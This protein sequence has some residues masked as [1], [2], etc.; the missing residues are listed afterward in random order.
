MFIHIGDRK[1]ISDK[2]CVGIFNKET[3][4]F[5]ADNQWIVDTIEDNVKT[6]AVSITNEF[7]TSRVSPFTILKRFSIKEDF[8]WRK[9][10]D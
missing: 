7:V 3:L 8:Y 1:I 10:D 6:V 9:K 4:D 5:A 2:R